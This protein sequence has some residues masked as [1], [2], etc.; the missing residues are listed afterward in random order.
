[1]SDP[2]VGKL[3][4]WKNHPLIFVSEALGVKHIS[5]QQ[6][7]GLVKFAKTK[8]MSIRSGHGT[9]KTDLPHGVFFGF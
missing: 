5:D 6:A 1:M 9:G 2:I 8:K 3:K 7:D 4:E